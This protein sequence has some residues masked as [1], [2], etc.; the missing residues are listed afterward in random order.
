MAPDRPR[1]PQS[2]G[3]PPTDESIMPR[4]GRTDPFRDTDSEPPPG[5]LR[6]QRSGFYPAQGSLGRYRAKDLPVEQL[7]PKRSNTPKPVSLFP[8]TLEIPGSV[9]DAAEKWLVTGA[10]DLPATVTARHA[11]AVQ[12]AQLLALLDRRG[13]AQLPLGF[14]QRAQ[15][16]FR[17]GWERD[18]QELDDCLT[19][20]QIPADKAGRQALV[21][22]AAQ[23]VPPSS[24]V[25]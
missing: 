16:L 2:D 3:E 25:E 19:I 5:S 9:A 7:R 23:L 21:A 11:R 4:A 14:Q 24:T 10:L 8:S 17:K 12:R 18:I 15:W 6:P 1:R 13:A 22:G 20:L